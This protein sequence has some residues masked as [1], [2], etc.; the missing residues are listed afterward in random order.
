M[1]RERILFDSSLLRIGHFECPAGEALWNREN[2][3]GGTLV[4]FPSVPVRIHQ[5]GHEPV[6]ADRNVV[7]YYN[8]DQPYRRGLLHRRGD[9]AV[10]IALTGDMA[11]SIA[12]EFR[13]AALD[14]PRSPFDRACGP[15]PGNCYLRHRALV[16]CIQDG[17]ILCALEVEEAAIEL[18]RSLLGADAAERSGR[19]ARRPSPGT[20]RERHRIAE[21]VRELLATEPGAPWSL[22]MLVDRVLLSPSHL[23]RVFRQQVG[24]PIHQYLGQLRLR[25]AASCV[26]AGEDDLLGLALRL[27]YSTHSHFTE[28]F[29]RAFGVPPSR[30]REH[31]AIVQVALAR[32]VG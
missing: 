13:A 20:A 7:M 11:A 28:A 12:G 23:C 10:W 5:A 17:R 26:L 6:V 32:S 21:S 16:E 29:R 3:I 1:P 27:G 2:V 8:A 4:V 19:C 25:E 15:S 14:N 30:L 24:M 9:D 22:D 18:V 31:A